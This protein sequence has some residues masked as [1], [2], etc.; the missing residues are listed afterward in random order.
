MHD[1]LVDKQ[2]SN[3]FVGNQTITGSLTLSSSAAIELNV[4]IRWGAAWHIPD[5]RKY[6]GTM[7]E[8]TDEYVKLRISEGRRPFVDSP[9]FELG[10]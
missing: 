10:E 4:P 2:S 5:I 7:Q 1:Q 6:T 3:I 9:H 8:A